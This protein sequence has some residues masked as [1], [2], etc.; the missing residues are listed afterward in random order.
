[1]L[2]VTEPAAAPPALLPAPTLAVAPP[3]LRSAPMSPPS[4]RSAATLNRPGMVTNLLP[5]PRSADGVLRGKLDLNTTLTPCEV[6][7]EGCPSWALVCGSMGLEVTTLWEAN[8]VWTSAA[9]TW[10]PNAEF[11]TGH[12]RHVWRRKTPRILLADWSLL[13]PDT[14]TWWCETSTELV[15]FSGKPR[16]GPT[17]PGWSH[18]SR[19]VSHVD[20]GGVTDGSWVVGV[21]SRIP[22]VGTP[23]LPARSRRPLLG[24]LDTTTPGVP[25]R[26]PSGSSVTVSEVIYLRPHLISPWGLLPVGKSNRPPSVAAPGIALHTRTGFVRRPFTGAE[27]GTAWDFPIRWVD[28]VG[29]TLLRDEFNVFKTRAPCKVL[30]LVGGA[31]ITWWVRGG[32]FLLHPLLRLDFLSLPWWKVSP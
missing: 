24:I 8:A 4:T 23:T 22:L 3:A 18:W 17:P 20:C 30:S 25:L 12:R 14:H 28:L 2:T 5:D 32:D 16:R 10:F 11:R 31:L 29:P 7:S 6:W 26:A 15:L 19:S 13:P 9:K 27:L 21:Y 1:M